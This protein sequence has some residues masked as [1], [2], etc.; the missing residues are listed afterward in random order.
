MV[1]DSEEL[2]FGGVGITS[3]LGELFALLPFE[4]ILPRFFE[5]S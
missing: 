4:C 3:M 2:L 5:M 1:A